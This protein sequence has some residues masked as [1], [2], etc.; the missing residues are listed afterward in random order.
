MWWAKCKL[1]F[2][3]S[4][5][6]FC[7]FFEYLW[8]Y[9]SCDILAIQT[10]SIFNYSYDSRPCF[11]STKDVAKIFFWFS[12]KIRFPIFLENEFIILKYFFFGCKNWWKVMN[13][14]QIL[15]FPSKNS[16]SWLATTFIIV[17]KKK[18]RISLILYKKWNWFF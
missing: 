16:T 18:S 14:K 9:T 15:H 13:E 4:G 3:F 6:N 7:L 10:H 12:V 11:C 8:V 1:Q 5:I 17:L 2:S